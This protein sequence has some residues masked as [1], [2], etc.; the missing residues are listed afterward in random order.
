MDR[1]AVVLAS[2]LALL[3]GGGP[4]DALQGGTDVEVASAE[5]EAALKQAPTPA[6][7]AVE[8][9]GEFPVSGNIRVP[10]ANQ[11]RIER[12]ITIRISPRGAA[13]PVPMFDLPERGRPPRIAEHRMG[14]CLPIGG[15]AGVQVGRDN[16]LTVFMRDRRTISLGLEKSCRAQDFY[17]GFYVERSLDGQLCVD[18]DRLQSRSGA[19]CALTRLRQLIAE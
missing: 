15:I 5:A 17:S 10:V 18:R 8:A 11:V 4:I 6:P 2:L 19:N 13:P 14:K 7:Q 9:F 16:R 12:Q 3:S 1:F